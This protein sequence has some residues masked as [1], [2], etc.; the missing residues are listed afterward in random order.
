[1]V[2]NI[3]PFTFVRYREFGKGYIDNWT[4]VYMFQVLKC[5]YARMRYSTHKVKL[6]FYI[7]PHTKDNWNLVEDI[8]TISKVVTWKYKGYYLENFPKKT[9]L[10]IWSKSK[11]K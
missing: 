5:L 3:L 10:K 1:M 8:N 11:N 9:C 4:E 7:S 2:Y 6:P